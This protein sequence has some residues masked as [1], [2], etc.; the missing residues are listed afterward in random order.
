VTFRSAGWRDGNA[1]GGAAR[2][3]DPHH[4]AR[5]APV[6]ESDTGERFDIQENGYFYLPGRIVHEAWVPAGSPAIMVLED[7]WKVNWLDG[8]PPRPPTVKDI[9]KGTPPG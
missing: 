9:G 5:I 6:R 1:G 2:D 8:P 4:S 7:G 3:G